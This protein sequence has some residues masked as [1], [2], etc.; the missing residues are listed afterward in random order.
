MELKQNSVPECVML[1][2]QKLKV[3]SERGEAGEAE[4]AKNLL[5]SLCENTE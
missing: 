1:K 4:N 5:K 2:L 3:L